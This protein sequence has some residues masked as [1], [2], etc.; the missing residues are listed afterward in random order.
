MALIPEPLTP[1]RNAAQLGIASIVL[2]GIFTAMAPVSLLLV[3]VTFA[4]GTH[5]Y[6]D[7]V[8]GIVAAIAGYMAVGFVLVMSFIGLW[9]GIKAMLA[10]KKQ[11][12]SMAVG[13]A[14]AALCVLAFFAWV[15]VA[16]AWYDPAYHLL[17]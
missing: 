15:G 1:A 6:F 2:G 7:R 11:G 4:G 17:R 9:F 5:V 3:V 13:F 16:L 8:G 14:G 10:A 12:E